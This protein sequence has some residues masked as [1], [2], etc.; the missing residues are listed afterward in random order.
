MSKMPDADKNLNV[1][2]NKVTT[3]N[4]QTA[5]IQTTQLPIDLAQNK[6]LVKPANEKM[7]IQPTFRTIQQPPQMRVVRMPGSAGTQII[8]TQIVPQTILKPPLQGR[9]TTITVSKSPTT[10][11]P[12]VTATLNTIQGTKATQ[13]RTPTPPTSAFVRT[14]ITP[15]TSSPT[16][17]LSQGT[18]AWVSGTGPMQVQVPTQLIR[19]TITQNRTQI[20]PGGQHIT[21]IFQPASQQQNIGGSINVSTATSGGHGQPTY[22]AT[23]LPQR[24]QSA[25]IVYTSQQQ[26]PFIQ[27]QVQ[28]MGITNNT[29]QV[30]PI[31]R[32]P[33][34]GLRVN[35]SSLSIRQNVPGLTPTTVIANQGRATAGQLVTSSTI[36]NTIP[37]RIIQ[38]QSQGASGT[39][40]IGQSNQKIL[41]A[42][43]MT[44]PIIMNNN[45]IGQ[46]VKSSLQPG[47]IAHVSKLTSSG[48]V[49]NDPN[50][51]V[52]SIQ[53]N[54]LQQQ[55]Q[56]TSQILNNSS[57][58][59]QQQQ[60]TANTIFTTQQ[61]QQLAN[62]SGG[63]IITVSQQQLINAPVQQ[64]MSQQGVVSI[65]V[66]GARGANI[67]IKTIT[68]STSNSGTL[69]SGNVHRNIIS[70]STNLQTTTIMPIAKIVSQQQSLMPQQQS[71]SSS[72]I[73]TQATPVYI[74]TRIPTSTLASSSS[75]TPASSLSTAQVIS[76]S[77]ASNARSTP[78][79]SSTG[80]TIFYEQT[81]MN[82][83]SEGNKSSAT[84]EQSS[85]SSSYAVVSASNVRY[86]EKVIHSIIASNYNNSAN[87]QSNIQSGQQQ[88][89]SIP[90]RFSPLVVDNQNQ[91]LQSHQIIS[92]ASQQNQQQHGPTVELISSS[93]QLQQPVPTSPRGSGSIL[94]K[95]S[96]ATSPMKAG[97]AAK[98]GTAKVRNF[99]LTAE[100][101]RAQSGVNQR[102]RVP[103]LQP[104][105]AQISQIIKAQVLHQ[106]QQQQQPL[107]QIQQQQHSTTSSPKA[108]SFSER[109]TPPLLHDNGD[110]WSDR[111]TTLSA[112]NSPSQEEEDDLDTMVSSS[113][114]KTEDISDFNKY[115]NKALG[116]ASSSG[117]KR[118][119]GGE[120]TPRK[121]FKSR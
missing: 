17:V 63:Q 73:S 115:A 70:N 106:Q 44:L 31:Q 9:S 74:H 58:Q 105:A 53:S 80:P 99:Q 45:R 22:V 81:S 79:F 60:Q 75:A 11:L 82:S 10:Y 98:K 90:I 101:L 113:F 93:V 96:E 97:P 12:R 94:K 108:L 38:V 116:K 25:T 71:V 2:Q 121:K 89:Q 13:I 87:I 43:V 95:H 88:Q 57:A 28:R 92:V 102:E 23:V 83:A 65:A 14:S 37:A 77:S 76:V 51:M 67:P 30:R 21:N 59:Q 47:I 35:T 66:G 120:S 4:I 86:G 15:R 39:S 33:T 114:K 91:A 103:T 27:G 107:Q 69:E 54:Q 20:L 6:V 29:R 24:P 46:S 104:S 84:N 119:A 26:Q 55:Q 5:N 34:T 40:Q 50:T 56:Q 41:S 68:V 118:E 52:A 36:S 112:P 16:A 7:A 62:Q 117:V 64:T 1:V 19:S 78:T 109:D 85:S 3:A 42:N 48:A 72:G 49:T 8:Q 18:T 61:A 100:N 110:D 32:L 111:S